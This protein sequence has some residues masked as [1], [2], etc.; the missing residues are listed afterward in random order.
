MSRFLLA[1]IAGVAA[2][3][4]GSSAPA[5]AHGPG[6]P[7]Y[8]HVTTVTHGSS[9]HLPSYTG[10]TSFVASTPRGYV[11]TGSSFV[12]STP[13]AYASTPHAYASTPHAYLT[14]YGTKFS[15][16]YYFGPTNFY[17]TNRSWSDRY[18]CWTYWNP[19]ASAWYYWSAAQ[20]FYYPISYI[21]I[22]PPVVVSAPVVVEPV[23][24]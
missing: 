5:H 9:Y 17:W 3:F 11:S 8:G 15:H 20:S 1:S 12:A 7:S 14:T 13:H 19:Y 18:G 21:T 24:P 16:G 6:G 2:L 23:V 10:S 4:L 22:A